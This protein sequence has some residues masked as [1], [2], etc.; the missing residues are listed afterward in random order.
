MTS[1]LELVFSSA[2]SRNLFGEQIFSLK[3][4]NRIWFGTP[5]RKVQSDKIGQNFFWGHGPGPSWKRLCYPFRVNSNLIKRSSDCCLL[6]L[7]IFQTMCFYANK[8][9]TNAFVTTCFARF[10][11]D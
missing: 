5:P 10:R 11:L 7:M 1:N 2:A 9:K 4:S 3:A 6:V 8:K